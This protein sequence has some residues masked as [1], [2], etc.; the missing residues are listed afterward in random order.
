MSV[1]LNTYLLE[2]QKANINPFEIN[3]NVASDIS[4]SLFE[5][6][7]ENVTIANDS[8]V[9]GRGIY[10]GKIGAFTSD[11]LSKEIPSLMAKNI[12]ESATYGPE[13]DPTLFVGKGQKYKKPKTYYPVLENVGVN[14]LTGIAQR[15]YEGA[16][17]VAGVSEITVNV[18]Y[19]SGKSEMNNSLGLKLSS[20]RNYVAVACE[21]LA[22]KDD[23]VES[24][25]DAKYVTEISSF[26]PESFGEE[27]AKGAI[28]KLGG[29]SVK[30]G[31]Y[32]IVID[33]DNI[34]TLLNALIGNL[35]A[36]DIQHGVSL[37]K[38]TKGKKVL[39]EKLSIDLKP[40]S[41]C[42]FGSSYD[43]EGTPKQNLKLVKNGVIQT[44]FYDLETAKKD[45]TT[46][47]GCGTKQGNNIRPEM[48]YIVVKPGKLSS[49]EL[50]SEVKNGIYINNLTGANAG[51]VPVS[52]DFSLQ[53][54]GCLIEDG[55]LTKPLSLI[56]LAG[57]LLTMFNEIKSIGSD[58]KETL[59]GCNCPSMSFESMSV[60]G[61]EE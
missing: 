4:V 8:T 2:A 10:N 39:S 36:F 57:N 7:V 17:R 61:V 25:F 60:S 51:L 38:D 49:D 43:A 56:T 41:D 31:K 29:S 3:V 26:D 15:V 5:G 58:S 19:Y 30:S 37:L 6:K 18:E 45:G 34:A 16:K 48:D 11:T 27:I 40:V 55:K 1:K 50:V 13:G 44:Y 46:S 22:K 42:V 24:N 35:S 28:N 9:T 14:E 12:V 47:N 21:L 54:S 53:A 23:L 52:G 20:K 33:Q 32:N 59:R